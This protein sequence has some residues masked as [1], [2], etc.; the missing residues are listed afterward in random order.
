MRFSVR[1]RRPRA[2]VAVQNDE[3]LLVRHLGFDVM[4]D[5]PLG[6][7]LSAGRMTSRPFLTLPHIDEHQIRMRVPQSTEFLDVDFFHVRLGVLNERVIRGRRNGLRL[8]ASPNTF[9]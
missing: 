9:L 2:R 7:V 4:L 3:G 6:N 8:E 5:H 1:E